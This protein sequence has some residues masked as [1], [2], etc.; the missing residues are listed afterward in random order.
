MQIKNLY[1]SVFGQIITKF[2][3]PIIRK[4]R[5]PHMLWGYYD[6]SG[7]WRPRTRISDSVFFYH[8]EKI[9]IEDNVFVWHYSILDGTG[10]LRID[11]GTQIGAWVGIFTHSSHIA[12]RVY[13]EHYTEVAEYEKAA[14]LVAPVNIGRYV[15]IGAGAKILP[16]VT[17]GDGALISA[18]TIVNKDIAPFDIVAGNPFLVI[19]DT[20]SIDREFIRSDN[21][22][23]KWYNEW[24]ENVI[25][26]REK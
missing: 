20:R 10:G 15:F 8:P 17:I 24:A 26:G 21:N 2:L 3:V 16:G 11:K 18:G 5:A 4:L 19:G 13:G 14:F 1:F 12:I 7:A 23:L 25:T 22:L 9:F 6:P